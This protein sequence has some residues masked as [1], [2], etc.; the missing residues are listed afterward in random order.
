MS[1]APNRLVPPRRSHSPGTPYF[2]MAQNRLKVEP[3]ILLLALLLCCLPAAE[4]FRG[5]LSACRTLRASG[6][7][8]AVPRS[9]PSLGVHGKGKPS[10]GP[11]GRIRTAYSASPLEKI[12]S[13]VRR[14][15]Q[16]FVSIL[17]SPQGLL[18]KGLLAIKSSAAC[19]S[20]ALKG[21]IPG[22]VP[23]SA[24]SVSASASASASVPVPAPAKKKISLDR[25]LEAR[26]YGTNDS[27][28]T[29]PQAS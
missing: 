7:L 2:S 29:C 22:S 3:M 26:K 18:Q 10:Y 1:I 28:P 8:Q 15:L 17:R 6:P 4:A 16:I 13:F 21:A 5:G 20:S 24:P 23:A 12:R 11:A 27:L 19:V 25:D 9:P 14:F